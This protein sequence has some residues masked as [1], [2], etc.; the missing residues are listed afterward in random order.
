MHEVVSSKG[1]ADVWVGGRVKALVDKTITIGT[2][3]GVKTWKRLIGALS[4]LR[5]CRFR[6]ATFRRADQCGDEL[7]N[8]HRATNDIELN[9]VKV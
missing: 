8:S 2:T 9:L 4:A 5:G 6:S 3:L 1:L 7:D